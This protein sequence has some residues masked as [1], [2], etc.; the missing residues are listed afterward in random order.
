MLVTNILKNII[1]SL[2]ERLKPYTYDKS[3]KSYW[4]NLNVD[5]LN[6]ELLYELKNLYS[7]LNSKPR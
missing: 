3:V 2:N 4:E 7:V 6:Y 5:M 1:T